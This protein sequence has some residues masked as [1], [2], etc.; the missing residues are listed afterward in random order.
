MDLTPY[1]ATALGTQDPTQ[2]LLTYYIS[3]TA[4]NA[5]V[6][7]TEIADPVN[8]VMTTADDNTV[9]I[10]VTNSA[11]TAP[12]YDVTPLVIHIERYA[13]PFIQTQNMV[14][15]ICVDYTNPLNVIRTLLLEATNT[16][17]GTY[18]YQWFLNGGAITG[19][20]NSTYMVDTGSPGQYTVE[21]TSVLLGCMA[22]SPTFE[23]IQSGPAVIPTDTTGYTVTNAFEQNQT[24]TVNIQGFGMSTYQYSLDDGPRQDSNVFENVTLGTHTITVWDNATGELIYNCD[25]LIIENVQIIDYP[26]YF[27][28]NGDGINDTWNISGLGGQANAKI[29]I[30]DRYGKLL[31]QISSTGTGWDGTFNGKLLP[32]TD[33]WFTVDFA[34]GLKMRQFKAHFAMKR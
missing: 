13:D 1:G 17:P 25:S 18:T 16:V 20:T 5:G 4:A 34:E 31:K 12:C 19:A 21:M 22:T 27:T 6:P 26:H 11:T 14:H 28:P 10:R 30:F 23:V 29:Y 15:T 24:I 3:Q 32:S 2:F 8:Y 33:Y 9:Y 7:G